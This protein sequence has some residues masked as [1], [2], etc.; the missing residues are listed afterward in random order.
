MDNFINKDINQNDKK[1]SVIILIILLIGVGLRLF[2]YLYNRSLWMDE[3]YLCSSFIHMNY[4]DLATKTLDYGQKAPIGFLWL[5]KFVVNLIGFNEMALR[6]I[7]LIAGITSLFIFKRVC[8]AFLNIQGQVIAIC[9]FSIAPALIYHSVEIKQYSTECL[10]TVIALYL[11]CIYANNNKWGNNVLWGICGGILIWFSFSVI[12]ILLGIA[13]GICL[14]HILKKDFKSLFFNA[15]PFTIWIISFI[16]NYTLFTHKQESAWVVYFFKVY[17]NFMPMPP[18]TLRELKWFPRNFLSMMDYPLGLIWV[19]NKAKIS[20]I[21]LALSIIP[22]ILLSIGMF[23]IFNTNRRNFYVLI[24]PLLMV[25]LASGLF[26][27]PLI[28]RFWI[29]TTPIFILFVAFGFEY[30]QRKIKSHKLILLISLAI[31]SCPF[32]QSLYFVIHPDRFY[33]HKNSAEKESLF[34][35]NNHFRQG[36]I[37]YNYWNNAPGYKVYKHIYNFKYLAIQGHDFRKTSEDL[38]DYNHQL[39]QDFN[40]FSGKKRVWLL[41]NNQFLTDIGDKIDDP[42]WYY[43]NHISPTDNLVAQ[44]SKIKK[45]IKKEIFKDITIYLFEKD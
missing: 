26:L 32:T 18:H 37:V 22:I 20:M 4:V 8:K 1:I 43:K 39:K 7:P 44:L 13:A 6:A 21:S 24:F 34:Y 30:Y 36:D 33:K 17:D 45:P 9:I 35:I 10:T 42:V 27:Y 14:N 2:H 23:S 40:E 19:F 5:T 3:V 11:Y 25:L 31:T 29:F 15:I 28:E 41:Y 12:F 38:T 16:L